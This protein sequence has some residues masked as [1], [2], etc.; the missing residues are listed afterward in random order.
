MDKPRFDPEPTVKLIRSG[1]VLRMLPLL[2]AAAVFGCGERH[3]EEKPSSLD[4][5]RG[6]PSGEAYDARALL[7]ARG[8][9]DRALKGDDS[10]IPAEQRAAF[11]GLR[12]FPPDSGFAVDAELVPFDPPRPVEMMATKG[13]IRHML[14]YGRLRFALAGTSYELTAYK[15]DST[16]P[17]LFVPFRDATNGSETYAVGRYIDLEEQPGARRYRLDFNRAYNPYCAYNV[18]YTCP[19]V[20]AENTLPVS[21]KAGERLPAS[22]P[23][24]E[25]GLPRH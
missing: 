14:R 18:G 25:G 21:V 10:P 5:S 7:V 20:P 23:H 13:D 4:P 19:I 11:A 8:E 3:A 6:V 1:I 17:L 16:T 12:Y 9:K 2:L 15:F 22:L 24:E